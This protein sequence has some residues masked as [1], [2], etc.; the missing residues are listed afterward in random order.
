MEG[1]AGA[2]DNGTSTTPAWCQSGRT[3]EGAGKTAAGTPRATGARTRGFN[4]S[5]P[6]WGKVRGAREP[7]GST[8]RCW[9]TTG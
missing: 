1:G 2:G 7:A 3:R 5:G 9:S 8:G 6:G 4:G